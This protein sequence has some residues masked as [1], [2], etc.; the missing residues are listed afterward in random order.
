[1]PHLARAQTS[2]FHQVHFSSMHEQCGLRTRLPCIPG[3]DV[4]ETGGFAIRIFPEGLVLGWD[5][6]PQM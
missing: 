5:C 2:T 1:M 3:A 6:P 4:A